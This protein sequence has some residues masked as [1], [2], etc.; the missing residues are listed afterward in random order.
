MNERTR[1]TQSAFAALICLAILPV[2]KTITIAPGAVRFSCAE[3]ALE[4][5]TLLNSTNGGDAVSFVVPPS[6][7]SGTLCT[8]TRVDNPITNTH[9]PIARSYDVK[10]WQRNPGKYVSYTTIECGAVS[11]GDGD[12]EYLCQLSLP[13]LTGE[14]AGYYITRYYSEPL[15]SRTLAARFLD[16]TTWGPTYEEIIDFES[17]IE[18]NG[19]RAYAE[20]V[21]AQVEMEATS[22]RAYFRTRLN[23]RT[24]VS[25]QYGIPGPRACDVNAKYRR[26]A[27]TYND[28]EL[29]RGWYNDAGTNGAP[30][31]TMGQNQISLNGDTVVYEIT[32]GGET[33][34]VL[35]SPLQFLNAQGSWQPLL[36]GEYTICSAEETVGVRIGDHDYPEYSL[37]LL[38][39]SPCTSSYRDRGGVDDGKGDGSIDEE[40]IKVNGKLVSVFDSDICTQ[41]CA[42][43]RPIQNGNPEVKLP[44]DW[45]L[46]SIN[47]VDLSDLNSSEVVN[48]N[49]LR[50]HDA[51]YMITVSL[52]PNCVD[53]NGNLLPDPA[54][55]AYT[56]YMSTGKGRYNLDMPVFARLPSTTPGEAKWALHDVRTQLR[57]NTLESPAMDGGGKAMRRAS[58]SVENADGQIKDLVVTRCINV[59]RN[60]FNEDYCKISYEEDACESVPKPEINEAGLMISFQKDPGGLEPEPLEKY[61]PKY[62]G[63]NGGGVVVCGS[64]NEV[65]PDVY[66]DDTFD[67]QNRKMH[68][69]RVNYFN[70]KRASF[71]ETI[72]SAPDQLCQKMGW[73]LAKI[74]ATSTQMNK[75]EINSETNINV[76]DNFVTCCHCTYKEVM[77]RSTYNEEM[78]S[79]LTYLNNKAVAAEYHRTDGEVR[80]HPDENYSREILQLHSIGLTKMNDDGTLVRD[81]FGNLVDNYTQQNIFTSAK[82]WTGFTESFRRGNYEDLDWTTK[83]KLDPLQI[84]SVLLRDWWPKI[85]LLEGYIGDRKPL[86]ADSPARSFLR[87]GATFRLLGGSDRPISHEDPNEWHNDK[88]I[89]RLTLDPQSNLYDKLCN[90]KN[91]PPPETTLQSGTG[92]AVY[93][94]QYKVGYCSGSN[95]SC[96][97]TENLL[98]KPSREPLTLDGCSDGP[99]D[100]SRDEMVKWFSVNSVDGGELRGGQL[101]QIRAAVVPF[102]K[103]DRVDFYITGN[104]NSANVK[105]QYITTAAPVENPGAVITTKYSA[106]PHITVILPPCHNSAGCQQA[107]RIVLRSGRNPDPDPNGPDSKARADGNFK[108]DSPCPVGEFDDA[109]DAVFD[110]LPSYRNQD[111]C[112]FKT[113]VTL[114]E[115]L[116]CHEKECRVDTIRTIE[117]VPG[118][119]YE[120]LRPEC[121]YFPF[122]QDA[123]KVFAGYDHSI[124]MCADKR[125]P[126]AL[127]TCCG[128]YSD[129]HP[130]D[131]EDREW[132]DVLS[133]YR[134]ELLTYNGNRER[135]TSWGR[136]ICDPERLG[137]FQGQAGH[138]IHHM[139][140]ADSFGSTA[141]IDKTKYH[142]TTAGCTIKV[143]VDASGMIAVVH[144]PDRTRVV[145]G[146]DFYPTVQSHVH[147]EKTV[148]FFFV[149]W[150]EDNTPLGQKSYPTSDN[151][152]GSSGEQLEGGFCLCDTTVVETAVF[153]SEPSRSQVLEQLHI[154]AFDPITFDQGEYEV[155]FESSNLMAYAKSGE[156][157]Y[158]KH[159]IFRVVPD[160][161]ISSEYIFLR[162]MISAV[163]VCQGEYTFRNSPS[164]YDA[165]N[166]ELLAATHEVDTYLD[167]I[168]DN[169]NTPPS[170]C[171]MLIKY[172]GYNNPRTEQVAH[173]SEA[174]K[175]GIFEFKTND[176][177]DPI[178]YGDSRRGNLAAV[179]ASI[180]LS[181]DAL[182]PAADADPSGGGLKSPLLKLLQVMRSLGLERL[183]HHRRTDG[184]VNQWIMEAF[185]ESQYEIPNQFSFYSLDF[186]PAGRHR[187]AQL[188]SP[189]AQLLNLGYIIAGQ[190]AL[191]SLFAY[192]LNSCG[193]GIGADWR[194]GDQFYKCG[195]EDGLE[196]F[197]SARLSFVPPDDPTNAED[198]VGTLATLLTADRISPTNRALIV[199]AY[200]ESSIAGGTNE[201]LKVAQSL[202]VSIPEF[203]TYNSVRT[204]GQVRQPSPRPEKNPNYGY[205]AIVSINLFGGADTMSMI[206]PHPQ[207]PTC[208]PLHAEY[209][210][211]RGPALAL[212]VGEMIQ[213]DAGDSNQPCDEFGVNSRLAAMAAMYSEGEGIFFANIGHLQSKVDRHDFARETKTQLFSHF[214]MKEE[215]FYVDA[216]HKRGLTGVLGRLADVLS[217]TMSTGQIAIDRMLS[218]NIGDPSLKRDVDIV[219]KRGTDPFIQSEIPGA[220]EKGRRTTLIDMMNRLNTQ[221]KPD[222]SSFHSEL[223]SQSFI[224]SQTLTEE[225]RLV[226]DEVDGSPSIPDTK[227]GKKLDMIFRL[228]LSANRESGKRRSVNRD[229]LAVEMDGYDQHFSL[230]DGLNPLFSELNDALAGFR[231]ALIQAGL[232]DRVTIVLTSEFGR[233]ITPNASGGIDHGWGGNSFIVGGAVRGKKIL[234]KH[235]DNYDLNDRYNT[236]QGAWIPTTSWEAMWYGI[237]QWAGVDNEDDMTYILPNEKN[238]GCDLYSESTLFREGEGKVSGCGG[239]EL[240]ITQTLVVSQPRLLSPEEQTQFCQL[241]TDGM[242]SVSVSTRCTVTGQTLRLLGDEG[243]HMLSGERALDLEYS[244]SS[245]QVGVKE[246]MIILVNSEEFRQDVAS[247]VAMDVDVGISDQTLAPTVGPTDLPSST[248]S[249]SL[250]P[251][252]EPSNVTSLSPT[253]TSIPSMR[254]SD[255]PSQA[256]SAVSDG[257][258]PTTKP[259]NRKRRRRRRN[260][261][262]YG[263]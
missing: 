99:N 160:E 137:P 180:V 100:F 171:K 210:L 102:S 177:A 199:D 10:D 114:D 221:N 189:E 204:N 232:W 28:V 118:T 136:S 196:Q 49:Q 5:P 218:V 3:Y 166:P 105:W 126:S 249:P 81:E 150:D 106:D 167:H 17:R 186:L 130:V 192:G 46:A 240:D 31:T 252:I 201:A 253:F 67:I 47:W 121:V 23:A 175:S 61:M 174:F 92:I 117:V 223:W 219:T 248:S 162:N 165:T 134:G 246:V 38:V 152:C 87:R 77:K 228:I 79:Q 239:D 37:Q 94:Q 6:D 48:L 123:A 8:L 24:V 242:S 255:F 74:F 112:D 178:S 207:M 193:G 244:I 128:G 234:G 29:S 222:I 200:R 21:K 83:S 35:D 90:P 91:P 183:S 104:P 161:F 217:R 75:D 7:S 205:K 115:N 256:P 129:R 213:I 176:G 158:S 18:T 262:G 78:A 85:D 226:L 230:K 2:V 197:S 135:C 122:Y 1:R 140:C 103:L 237:V 14:N 13:A 96:M 198:V 187:E 11:S 233:S 54:R 127:S 131:R 263:S 101:I 235:P 206:V 12:D 57:T 52:D 224:D 169:P 42:G 172:F 173:C 247:V 73:A 55:L 191:Y 30:F 34:T 211:Q 163:E 138:C 124:A 229:F 250:A 113:I 251:T 214:S 157:A 98:S 119:Y 216:F 188:V 195:N 25:Y 194:R 19:T 111:E 154:G 40:Q 146:A 125:L 185:G 68:S 53:M 39:D 72:L 71:V 110:V 43:S 220:S 155:L 89:F 45:D 4:S 15:P 142:W 133:E 238:F 182:S 9:I 41:K 26:F 82:I 202:L 148:S 156:G 33:R 241:V 227:L 80:A 170:V 69:H 32:F 44:S 153:E 149:H 50:T 179:A 65:R 209:T 62:A 260:Y 108:P 181:D 145:N 225:Y 258:K 107:V 151:G 215:G 254:R 212:N 257:G 59:Q 70:L 93:S 97:A 168:H 66:K 27:F 16:R 51:S 58:R 184:Y 76:L 147:H 243:N 36:D 109:D 20:W 231:L 203:H 120:Y 143:K 84:E 159:T 259:T 56:D 139:S 64:P 22:H 208:A 261:F 190:N 88:D 95:D 164:Y 63:P 144:S 132:A 245:D 60:V 116:A 236:G 141:F 86:C